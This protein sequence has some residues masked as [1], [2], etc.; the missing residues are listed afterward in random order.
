MKNIFL[1]E[2][3]VAENCLS[4]IYNN[5]PVPIEYARANIVVRHSQRERLGLN[6]SQLQDDTRK[7]I[8]RLLKSRCRSLDNSATLKVICTMIGIVNVDSGYLARQP[9]RFLEV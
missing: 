2:K 5:M 9:I 6:E 7:V 1:L 3:R 4:T 8:V